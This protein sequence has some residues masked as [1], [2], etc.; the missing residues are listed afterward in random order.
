MSYRARKPRHL[1]FTLIE[2]LVT[3]AMAA[4]LAAVAIPSYRSFLINQQLSTVSSN[5][6]SAL[7]QARSEAM[8]LGKYVALVPI[9]GT[10]WSSGWQLKVMNNSCAVT[11]DITGNNDPLPSA[12]TINATGTTKSFAHSTPS[13]VYA[14]SGFPFTACASPYYSG[15]MNG[16]I[17]FI[18]TETGRERVIVAS[19]T[20]RA[21]ICDPS[22]ET[23]AA[24]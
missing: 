20:G 17:K 1:G 6:L 9:D 3:L 10:N 4:V 21:R 11:G 14:A 8:R 7:L 5:F 19:K 23:C 24:D 12:V 13:Y 18:A 15:D 16:T 22:R 2:M